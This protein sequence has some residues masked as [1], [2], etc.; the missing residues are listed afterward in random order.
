M[1]IVVIFNFFKN[2]LFSVKER[3][4]A[5]SA[6]GPAADP[7]Q[8]IGFVPRAR[9]GGMKETG[10]ASTSGRNA[11]KGETL[12]EESR[13]GL[14]RVKANDADIDQDLDD[15]NN[16]IA[17]LGNIAA[18]MRDEA[19][20]QNK[21]LEMIDENMGRAADKQNVVNSRQKRYLN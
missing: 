7:N 16:A 4:D 2:E 14:E 10:L 11:K 8:K 9:V 6:K 20:V 1:S 13:L 21:K 15:I 5:R 12:D 18:Q 19:I 17:G 3:N